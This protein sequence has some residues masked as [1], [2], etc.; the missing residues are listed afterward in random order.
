MGK[1]E[2]RRAC[3][4]EH[5]GLRSQRGVGSSRDGALL[6]ET[7]LLA[8]LELHLDMGVGRDP[9]TAVRAADHSLLL[10]EHQISSDCGDR[11]ARLE[12]ERLNR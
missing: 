8:G 9:G 4:E 11:C 5:R 6:G 12:R 1:L 7:V 10:E 2:N 3:V